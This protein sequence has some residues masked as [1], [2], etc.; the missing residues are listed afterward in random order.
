MDRFSPEIDADH[1]Q[2]CRVCSRGFAKCDRQI[3]ITQLI[4]KKFFELTQREVR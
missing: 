1:K 2:K 4:E 3:T